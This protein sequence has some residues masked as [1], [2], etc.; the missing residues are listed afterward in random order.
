M[1][2]IA[3]IQDHQ[4]GHLLPT[5][6]L[7]R[8]L[9]ERGHRTV[10]LTAADGG[11]FVRQNGFEFQ[12]ILE[13]LY[14]KG[15]VQT[16]REGGGLAPATGPPAVTP[17]PM[18]TFQYLESLVE[19]P[20][21]A[22]TVRALDPDLFLATT[23]Y[24]LVPLTLRLRFDVPVVLL[25][26]Y[27]R[28]KPRTVMVERVEALLKHPFP[29]TQA[30]L[31]LARAVWRPDCTPAELARELL[32]MRELMLCPQAL[33]LPWRWQPEHE[34]YYV[35]GPVG[36]E[37]LSE[38]GDSFPWER[39]DPGKK[40]LYGSMGSQSQVFGTEALLKFY[41]IVAGVARKEPGWQ[42]VLATGG[43]VR[44]ED[45]PDLPADAILA[46]WVPQLSLL[47]R[48]AVMITHGGLGAIREAIAGGVPLIVFPFINDQ[49]FNAE[50]IV[51][52][53]L[54]L[55]GTFQKVSVRKLRKMVRRVDGEPEFRHN[56]A[57]MHER[58]LEVERSGIGVR[59]IEEILQPSRQGGAS[60][61]LASSS[62]GRSL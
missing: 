61:P 47:K 52:H 34:V 60:G 4:E 17:P 38:R 35:E 8:R 23:L 18:E 10:Y 26:P 55:A 1:A 31:A 62:T 20:E 37:R 40:L 41:R 22:A 11:D 28:A 14:P 57:R 54:G 39:L 27:L 50:R 46:T 30:L 48:A 19:R 32:A 51:H 59:L 3:L 12:P 5:F 56:V 36:A 44:R 13:D 7:A 25:T 6:P 9:E 29:G 24:P 43:L 2:T 53:G 58:F 15:L 49:P 33:D 16:L 45:L 42:L 21:L